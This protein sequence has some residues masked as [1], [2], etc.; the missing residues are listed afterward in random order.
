MTGNEIITDFRSAVN[1]VNVSILI[2]QFLDN[3]SRDFEKATVFESRIQMF[4]LLLCKV[5]FLV[6]IWALVPLNTY[7]TQKLVSL[8]LECL[9]LVCLKFTA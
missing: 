3:R 6:S 1:R 7:L 9:F 5:L 2:F 4:G 8:P